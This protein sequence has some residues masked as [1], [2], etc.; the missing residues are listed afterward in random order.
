MELEKLIEWQPSFSVGI[1]IIDEQHKVLIDIINKLYRALKQG[2]ARFELNL[3]LNEVTD[4]TIFH[5]KFE[6]NY[7]EKFDYSKKEN[8]KKEHE[9]FVNELNSLKERFTKG[10]AVVSFDVMNLLRNWLENHI[11]LID[12]QYVELFKSNGII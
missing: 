1:N 3:I 10:D 4:Y 8:H 2:K 5:F 11:K 7:F 9:N 12:K 6:E